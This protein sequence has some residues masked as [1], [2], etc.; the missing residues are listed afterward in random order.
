MIHRLLKRRYAAALAAILVA[1]LGWYCYGAF[2]E[3]AAQ[4]RAR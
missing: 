3:R 4:G 2:S 1:F